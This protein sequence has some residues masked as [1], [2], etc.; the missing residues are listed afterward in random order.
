MQNERDMQSKARQNTI[1]NL[2]K[3]YGMY[4]DYTPE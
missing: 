3:A 2:Q 1:S 4:Y